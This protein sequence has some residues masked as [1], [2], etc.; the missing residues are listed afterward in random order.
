MH[1]PLV[2]VVIA[3]HNG[4]LYLQEAIQSVLDQEYPN[5]ELWVIDNGSTDRTSTVAKLFPKVNYRYSE[6]GNLSLARNL[7]VSLS[8]GDYIAFLDHDDIWAPEKLTKQV[9]FLEANRQYGIV[10]GLQK[11]FLQPGHKKPDWIE[12]E[13]IDKLQRAYLASAT[14]VR[15]S[16]F[17]ALGDFNPAWPLVSDAAWL[18]N[19]HHA[20]IQ[21]GM[22]EEVL[23]HR[24]I[25]STNDSRHC[26]ALY[27]QLL[28]ALKDCR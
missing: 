17:E 12:Q 18:F 22:I 13:S 19:A 16:L 28:W 1:Q 23:I 26:E 2:S 14:M 5:Y 4:E 11:N 21:M 27:K 20:G 10:L 15:R 24:R 8:R 25:H 3:V 9:Q 7:G 6:I